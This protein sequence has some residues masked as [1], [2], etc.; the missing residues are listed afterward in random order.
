VGQPN[1]ALRHNNHPLVQSQ[2]T[3]IRQHKLDMT[4]FK[5][6]KSI[7]KNTNCDGYALAIDYF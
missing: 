5:V 3:I 2:H 6:K 1:R 4:I 7:K